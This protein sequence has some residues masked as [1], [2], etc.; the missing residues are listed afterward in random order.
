MKK[1]IFKLS[2]VSAVV[3][4]TGNLFADNDKMKEITET[5]AKIKPTI[6]DEAHE[7][8]PKISPIK[9][10]GESE[11]IANDANVSLSILKES[12]Q[13]S[14]KDLFFPPYRCFIYTSKKKQIDIGISDKTTIDFKIDKSSL[15]VGD[16]IVVTNSLDNNSFFG[17]FII[18][19]IEIKK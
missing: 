4:F 2:L 5:H 18:E 1:T 13:I 3:L 16:T 6:V 8:L 14:R 9:S 10:G 11:D 19:W 7:K 15:S 12:Y 17:K